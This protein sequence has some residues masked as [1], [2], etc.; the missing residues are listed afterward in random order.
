MRAD[1]LVRAHHRNAIEWMRTL[2]A[3]LDPNE[4]LNPGK[5]L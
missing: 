1:K 2:K 3:A 5:V 4:I